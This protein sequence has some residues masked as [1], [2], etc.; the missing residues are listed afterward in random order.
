MNEKTNPIKDAYVNTMNYVALAIIWLLFS[1]AGLLITAGASL[2]AVFYVAFRVKEDA[3]HTPLVKTFLTHLKKTIIPATIAYL[4]IALFAAGLFFIHNYAAAEEAT[5]VRYAVY[6]SGFYLVVFSLY[7]FPVLGLFNH[8][9]PLHLIRNILIMAHIHPFLTFRLLG[10]LAL[11]YLVVFLIH[12]VLFLPAF[13]L[14]LFLQ[15]SHMKPVFDIYIEKLKE[16]SPD[17]E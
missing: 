6:F 7:V 17:E 12:P 16:D 14:Y 1:M 2:S 13:A 5:L 8:K 15:T 3:R 11:L 9:N 4:L 10:T